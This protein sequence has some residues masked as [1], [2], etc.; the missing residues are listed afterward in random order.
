VFKRAKKFHALDH[1]V[2]V[3]GQK[4]SQGLHK[5]INYHGAYKRRNLR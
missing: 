3:I 4:L 2:T 5:V 1:A